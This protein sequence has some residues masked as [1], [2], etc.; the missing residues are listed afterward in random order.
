M[1]VIGN[2]RLLTK[3]HMA[4][5]HFRHV[6]EGMLSAFYDALLNSKVV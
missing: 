5:H 6:V 4:D 3:V 2:Q 1:K